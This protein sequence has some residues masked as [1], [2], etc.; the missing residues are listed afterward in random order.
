[1]VKPGN[2]KNDNYHT[3]STWQWPGTNEKCLAG[4]MRALEL[5]MVVES[6]N[7]H[8]QELVFIMYF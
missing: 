3:V 1:M 7:F 2:G 5:Q 6:V 4:T 8:G